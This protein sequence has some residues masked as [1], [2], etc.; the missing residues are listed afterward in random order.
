[1]TTPRP[2]SL[3]DRLA[4]RTGLA[5]VDWSKRPHRQVD[6]TLVSEGRQSSA[7]WQSESLSTTR[8]H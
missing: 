8:F 4:L 5:L 1:M 7:A 2:E 3:F 6:G